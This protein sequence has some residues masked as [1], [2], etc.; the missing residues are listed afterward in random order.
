MQ[1]MHQVVHL[2]QTRQLHCSTSAL[3]AELERDLHQP[4]VSSM[5]LLAH[6]VGKHAFTP[7][8]SL[9]SELV[10]RAQCSPPNA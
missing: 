9:R 8:P 6:I 4:V 2:L 5:V 7:M 10:W 1:A 3:G